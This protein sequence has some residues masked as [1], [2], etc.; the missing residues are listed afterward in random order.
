M[1]SLWQGHSIGTK[2]FDIATLIVIFELYLENF[3]LAMVITFS[4]LPN[5]FNLV[6]L[7]FD[8]ATLML[9]TAG[10][11]HCFINTVIAYIFFLVHN[12]AFYSKMLL[13]EYVPV[14]FEQL[15]PNELHTKARMV[16]MVYFHYILR[17][18]M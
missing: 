8:F 13:V 1:Y 18:D 3:I 7:T 12:R 2:T 14:F 6:S 17:S 11:D 9:P 4:W 5:I 10:I 16:H 15:G